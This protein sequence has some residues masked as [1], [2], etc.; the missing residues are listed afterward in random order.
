MVFVQ[1]TLS[2]NFILTWNADIV[3]DFSNFSFV[4]KSAPVGSLHEVVLN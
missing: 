1:E 2:F 3:L 4:N